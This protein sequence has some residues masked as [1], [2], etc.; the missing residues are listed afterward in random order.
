MLPFSLILLSIVVLMALIMR[1]LI[2]E[3]TFIIRRYI[4]T[5][6]RA[7][8]EILSTKRAPKSWTRRLEQRM[9]KIENGPGGS[10][11]RRKLEERA[12]NICLQKI[13]RLI[14][15]F[16]KCSLV[17]NEETRRIVLGELKKAQNTWRDKSWSE[18]VPSA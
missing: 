12:K 7:V 3:A 16:G 10:E 9:A 5:K 4:E 1:G 8:E 14:K 17:E 6:N 18:I 11:R 13:D 15:Y 2:W